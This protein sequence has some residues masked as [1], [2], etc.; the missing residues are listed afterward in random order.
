MSS[1]LYL[2]TKIFPS[3]SIFFFF[4]ALFHASYQVKYFHTWLQMVKSKQ[5]PSDPLMISIKNQKT[6]KSTWNAWCIWEKKFLGDEDCSSIDDRLSSFIHQLNLFPFLHMVNLY[7]PH[8]KQKRNK[9][10]FNR[11]RN[12]IIKDYL[13]N[14]S[15]HDNQKSSLKQ[16]CA[17]K[18]FRKFRLTNLLVYVK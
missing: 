18:Q 8:K 12:E 9:S 1:P 3:T 17:L 6:N 4:F 11:I 14:S 2:I 7:A 15:W 16:A 13:G 5:D 10:N